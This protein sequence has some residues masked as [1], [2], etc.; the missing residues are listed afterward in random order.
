MD[1]YLVHNLVYQSHKYINDN[2]PAYMMS[3]RDIARFKQLYN[4][5]FYYLDDDEKNDDKKYDDDIYYYYCYDDDVKNFHY[6][7]INV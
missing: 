5:I 4:W 3:L 6:S 1:P 2:E 7:D